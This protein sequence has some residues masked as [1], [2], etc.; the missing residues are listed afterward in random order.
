MQGGVFVTFDAS[1]QVTVAGQRVC[2]C[3]CV[4]GGGGMLL[5]S[6]MAP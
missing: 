4:W 6:L 3:V 5:G 1:K 2:V